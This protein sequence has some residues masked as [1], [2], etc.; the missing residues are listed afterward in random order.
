M[1][2]VNSIFSGI[3]K[4]KLISFHTALNKKQG[5]QPNLRNNKLMSNDISYIIHKNFSIASVFCIII[6][7]I[8]VAIDD[9]DGDFD[10][11]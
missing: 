11:S 2:I 1:L 3:T 9:D 6:D 7:A 10:Y 4:P 5:L 8:N